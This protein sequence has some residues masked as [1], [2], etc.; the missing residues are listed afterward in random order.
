MSIVRT[1]RKKHNFTIIDNTGLIDPSLTWKETGLLAFLMTKPDDWQVSIKALCN[2]KLDGKD[3]VAAALKGLQEKG[4]VY[5]IDDRAQGK[6]NTEYLVFETREDLQEWLQDKDSHRDGFSGTV[7]PERLNRDGKTGT[8]N[9]PLV[10]TDIDITDQQITE[11]QITEEI[12][13]IVPHVIAVVVEE[14]RGGVSQTSQIALRTKSKIVRNPNGSEQ[15]PWE[16]ADPI[17]TW[18]I[19][20]GFLKYVWPFVKDYTSFK[21]IRNLPLK[22]TRRALIKY[23]NKAHYEPERR[24]EMLGHWEDYQDGLSGVSDTYSDFTASQALSQI[25]EERIHNASKR[26]FE[27]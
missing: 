27:L 17:E 24:E 4:Y 7:K 1:K 9:P 3:A 20:E 25:E 11:K 10:I 16:E 26:K 22:A 18:V 5:R 13:P 19:E 12:P 8:E 6:F 21:N 23:I 14:E 2:N 15:F